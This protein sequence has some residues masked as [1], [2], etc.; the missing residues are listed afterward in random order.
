M[1]DEHIVSITQLNEMLKLTENISCCRSEDIKTTYSWIGKTLGKF[2]YNRLRKKDKNI[3][4]TYI[5]DITGYSDS[6]I[7]KL[8]RRKKL[9]KTL[10]PRERSQNVFKN[11]YSASDISLLSTVSNAYHGQNGHALKKVLRE[12]YTIHQ[13]IR[14]ERLCN[15]SVSHIYNL[16]KT[17]IY[18]S[19]TLEYTKTQATKVSIGERRKPDHGDKP[20][21]LRVD[22]VHQ[23]DL[24]KQ[25]GVYH[26][27]IIDEYTQWEY[28]GCVSQIS[29][30]HL[31][32]LLHELILLFPFKVINFHS[33]N[34]S[35]YINKTVAR[36]LSKL[37][38]SQTKSRSRRT[39]D[40][41]LVE[42]KNASVVRKIMGHMHIPQGCASQI[43]SFY[44]EHLDEFLNFHRPCA[45]PTEYIDA[46][47]KIKKKYE[48]YLT[49]VEKLMSID[50]FK[51]FLREGVTKEYLVTTQMR[52]T[53]LKS[54]EDLRLA[55][56]KLFNGIFSK[57]MKEILTA[58]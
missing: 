34:G 36:L 27:N 48:I 4:K 45:F 41:A 13:D 2:G 5:K 42:G 49:P 28:V 53:H 15:I 44:R 57:K 16:K 20:G 43:N 22:S 30:Y 35:E 40:N 1:N 38:V 6:Q 56:T 26:I 9:K 33:D 32:P 31:E 50:D 25:K 17:N 47:G 51:I 58:L 8:I 54:A 10:K 11:V 24:D 19:N 23:G 37:S 3:V 14:F 21:S 52:K 46:R 55:K 7:D 39:N 18:V 12:M 29:E